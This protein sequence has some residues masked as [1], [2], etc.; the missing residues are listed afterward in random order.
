MFLYISHKNLIFP[1]NWRISFYILYGFHKF[2]FFSRFGIFKIVN[3]SV[4]WNDFQCFLAIFQVFWWNLNILNFFVKSNDFYTILY[5]TSISQFFAIFLNSK[6]INFP[7]DWIIYF[8][9]VWI[10]HFF[11]FQKSRI[12][13]SNQIIY[14][15]LFK[16]KK[17]FPS[18]WKLWQFHDFFS[19]FPLSGKIWS[20]S[21]NWPKMCEIGTKLS[22]VFRQIE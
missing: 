18:N 16:V 17:D 20:I 13:P 5:C 11:G 15:I 9:F 12:F 14:F 2:F 22:N 4:K 8:I 19:I 7:S 10:S 6:I 1:S 21:E 3:F